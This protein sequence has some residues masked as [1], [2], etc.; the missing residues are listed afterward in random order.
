M[1]VKTNKINNEKRHDIE[2][3]RRELPAEQ[4]GGIA[5]PCP[6]A[7]RQRKSWGEGDGRWV[8]SNGWHAQSHKK[9]RR[10][11]LHKRDGK[12][13][14]A[15]DRAPSRGEPGEPRGLTTFQRTPSPKLGGKKDETEGREVK[16]ERNPRRGI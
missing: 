9:V 8:W 15:Q 7:T 3:E 4:Q 2:N 1:K 14:L 6:V 16:R 13:A 11:V 5:T 12:L 10:C